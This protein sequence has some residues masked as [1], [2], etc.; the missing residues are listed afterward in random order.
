MEKSR[1]K[2]EEIRIKARRNA[3]IKARKKGR[4]KAS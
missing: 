1:Y 4:K 2:A 3:R